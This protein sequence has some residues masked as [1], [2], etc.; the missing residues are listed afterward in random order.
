MSHFCVLVIGDG[1]ED[2]LA[3]YQENNMG[4]CPQEYMEFNNLEEEYADDWKNGATEMLIADD[5]SYHTPWSE[6]GK[7]LKDAGYEEKVVRFNVIY[8]EFSKYLE[9]WHNACFNAEEGAYGYYENPNAKW[10]W[11]Q[12]GGRWSGYFRVKQG[13]KPELGERSWMDT[14]SPPLES[15]QADSA[16]KKD[17]DFD[18]M[19]DENE[20]EQLKYYHEF[21]GILKGTPIIPWK[22]FLAAYPG[23][24]ET[25]RRVYHAQAGK[26]LL[27]EARFYG[28][29][30]RYMQ[31]EESFR[32]QVRA[33][34]I[35]PFAI[36]HN[37]EWME[38]GSMGWWGMVK[39][40]K[41]REQHQE[42]VLQLIQS[43]P[44]DT[45]LTIVDCHI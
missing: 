45:L 4:D 9:D 24:V 8:P 27:A 23:D 41:D 18:L 5:G 12:I 15:N 42:E 37:G 32:K 33:E 11:Y 29:E 43:L 16:L 17:I 25:A 28:D 1:V 30:E 7:E 26:Q 14:D 35:V 13:V 20:Q 3:P 31:D 39:D 10:D 36:L 21:Y 19:M 2:Q 38:R 40:K 6:R 44:D 34:A 22:N